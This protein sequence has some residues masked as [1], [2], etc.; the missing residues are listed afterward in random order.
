METSSDPSHYCYSPAGTGSGNYYPV[1]NNY[2]DVTRLEQRT[3]YPSHIC[4]HI[5][6]DAAL[7]DV[8]FFD[9]FDA[10]Y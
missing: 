7:T 10:E 5:V 1:V 6:P 3:L 8:I 9:G 2:S 4:S